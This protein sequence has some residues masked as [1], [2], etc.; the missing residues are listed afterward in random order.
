MTGAA[1]SSAAGVRLPRVLGLRDLVL[2]NVVGVT[3]LRWLATSA[4]AGPSVLSLWVLAALFFFVPLGL[5]VAELSS[6]HPQQ[7]GV[8]AWTK[9][10]FG[11][12]HGFLCG[13]CYWV[14]NLLY[15]PNLLMASAVM[16]T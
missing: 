14:N 12:G 3:S 2:L 8:Y 16:A 10:A 11:E 7:G 13:W 15:Y 6:R 4:A 1:S 9:A 5:A